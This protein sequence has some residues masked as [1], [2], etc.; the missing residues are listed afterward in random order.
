MVT[1][2]RDLF[3]AVKAPARSSPEEYRSTNGNG[4]QLKVN[5]HGIRANGHRASF[6]ELPDLT[7]MYLIEIAQ[8]DLLTREE[9]RDVFA[10]IY[11]GD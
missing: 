6:E 5:G 10:K 1:T 3:V 7:E 2:E 9:E 4:R 11:R 8:Y